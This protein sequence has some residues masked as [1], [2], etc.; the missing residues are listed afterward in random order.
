M[1]IRFDNKTIK[2]ICSSPANANKRLGSLRAK[3]LF[4]RI[5]QI[6]AANN[7]DELRPPTP[8]KFHELIADRK[9]Q[10][11][12]SLGGNWRLIFTVSTDVTDNKNVAVAV[13]VEVVDYH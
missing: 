1:E 3:T 10:W 12:C 5:S 11:A 8:G 4:L 6:L 13:I 2:G 7:V 9:G